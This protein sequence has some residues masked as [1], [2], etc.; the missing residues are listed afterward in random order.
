MVI[1]H[2]FIVIVFHLVKTASSCQFVVQKDHG[3]QGHETTLSSV[4]LAEIWKGSNSKDL[5]SSPKQHAQHLT[6]GVM[7]PEDFKWIESDRS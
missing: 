5:A 6:R 2:L 7:N 3:C 4:L 1:S